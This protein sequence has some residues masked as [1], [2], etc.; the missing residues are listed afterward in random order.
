[1][2]YKQ[3]CGEEYDKVV[4]GVCATPPAV[5]P[6]R[7]VLVPRLCYA[8]LRAAAQEIPS[9]SQTA[10]GDRAAGLAGETR[11]LGGFTLHSA[12]QRERGDSNSRIY[13]AKRF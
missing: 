3:D 4:A 10:G 5:R 9:Q 6:A 11:Q 7:L 2:N 8:G 1:M 13:E 12:D